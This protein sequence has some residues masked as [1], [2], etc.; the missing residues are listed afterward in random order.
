MDILLGRCLHWK[1]WCWPSLLA[2]QP[3]AQPEIV[4]SRWRR[5]FSNV[6]LLFR[7]YC[8]LCLCNLEFWFRNKGMNVLN[9]NNCDARQCGLIQSSCSGQSI[10]RFLG[11]SLPE[12]LMLT[13]GRVTYKCPSRMAEICV[14]LQSLYFAALSSIWQKPSYIILVFSFLSLLQL[15]W[16]LV[17]YFQTPS[18]LQS[19]NQKA[20]PAWRRVFLCVK[21]ILFSCCSREEKML[22]A[23]SRLRW[24]LSDNHFSLQPLGC[25]VILLL[26]DHFHLLNRCYVLCVRSGPHLPSKH[27]SHTCKI[28]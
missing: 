16:E 1:N 28:Q 21:V 25:H 9:Q 6:A 12:Y 20:T 14:E 17:K 26:Q 11:R 7:I 15:V 4:V 8:N 19:T 3:L 27:C 2:S 5:D 23:F 13:A 24:I 18:N 22:G 10:S